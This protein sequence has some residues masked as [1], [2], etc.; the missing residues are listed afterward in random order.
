M[1][2][3]SAVTEPPTV[4]GGPLMGGAQRRMGSSQQEQPPEELFAMPV[5]TFHTHY[6]SHTP[7]VDQQDF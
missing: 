1:P 5:S 2:N 7:E 6:F 4:V 3:P